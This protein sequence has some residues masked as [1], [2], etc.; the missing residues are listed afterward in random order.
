ME[1]NTGIKTWD[2]YINGTWKGSVFA[3]TE[4]EAISAGVSTFGADCEDQVSVTER[5]NS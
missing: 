1:I 2:V 5:D 4:S 3:K